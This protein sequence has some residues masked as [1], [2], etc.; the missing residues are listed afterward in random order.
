MIKNKF[1]GVCANCDFPAIHVK[2]VQLCAECYEKKRCSSSAYKEMNKK[3]LA[4][5]RMNDRAPFMFNAVKSKAKR[6][7]RDFKLTL[8]WIR[9]KLNSGKCDL[10]GLPFEYKKYKKGE[11]GVRCFYA[12]S[13]DRVDNT[14]DY[15]PSNCR[16]VVWGYNLC[17]N[18][19]ADND[20]MALALSLV[21]NSIP[22]KNRT[23][24]EEELSPALL[25]LLPGKTDSDMVSMN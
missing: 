25:S 9:E 10:S 22:K 15:T 8:D 11:R 17:K 20:V 1:I 4:V 24:L 12:P 19:H 7:K 3:R 21:M 13:I 6:E 23:A 16:M 2:K 5:A 14:R 18:N